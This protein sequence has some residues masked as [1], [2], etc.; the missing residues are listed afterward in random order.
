VEF[1]VVHNGNLS[2]EQRQVLEGDPQV[3]LVLYSEP[4]L[5]L[6][7]KINQ[8]VEAARGTFVCLLNDDVEAITEAGGEELVAFMLTHPG[9]GAMG[10]LCLF[11]NGTIQHDGILMLEQGPSHAGLLLPTHYLGS[12]GDLLHCR[13]EVFGVTGAVMV[14]RRSVFLDL[15]GFSDALP[16]N[17]NDVDFCV[18]LRQSGLTCVVDPGVR[19]YHFES[20]TKVGTFR[21]EKETLFSAGQAVSAIPTSIRASTSETRPT[22]SLPPPRRCRSSRATR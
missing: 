3:R 18:R 11:E 16:L 22:R 19:L 14:V 12:A 7:R 5:N 2:E 15:G 20:A 9:V 4:A 17:Y 1:V 6:S 13:R 10:T 21:C 8:G